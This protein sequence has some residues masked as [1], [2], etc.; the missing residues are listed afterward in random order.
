MAI[1]DAPERDLASFID[2]VCDEAPLRIEQDL[3]AG[4]VR[5][6]TSEAEKRQAAQ[7]IRCSEDIV[8][9]LLRNAR[10]AHAR[11]IFLSVQRDERM[12]TIVVIDDGDG[13]PDAMFERIFESRV[14]SKLDTAHMDKWGMHG[15]GMALYSIITNAEEA[16]VGASVVGEGTA[17]VVRTNLDEI[18]ERT[19]QSTFPHFEQKDDGVLSMRGP[20][21]MLR[22]AAEFALECKD[23]VDVYEGSPTEIAAALYAFGTATT[24]PAM[25]A[26]ERSNDADI[27]PV[28]RLAY[29]R[30]P[31]DLA[32]KAASLGLDLSPRSAR[33]IMNGEI[34]PPDAL[35][36]RLRTESM[37]DVLPRPEKDAPG[38]GDGTQRKSFAEAGSVVTARGVRLTKR[39][40]DDLAEGVKEAFA[41]VAD[42]YFLERDVTPDI[43]VRDGR[44]IVSI[45]LVRH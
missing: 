43:T 12:R 35:Y 27:A 44:L 23:A 36:V 25:R 33:R 32:Q 5:L 41:D 18:G 15:R 20:R 31:E 1:E 3:G 28:K 4:F 38:G 29:A 21:N 24:T 37:R 7:D 10:D 9:E 2:E 8:I 26:F 34:A 6:R 14:T 40:K 13:I 42:A 22:V 19:D 11:H 45:P 16:F 39:D 30:D 17:I